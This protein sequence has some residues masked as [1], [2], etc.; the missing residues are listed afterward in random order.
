MIRRAWIVGVSVAA[1]VGC[2]GGGDTGAGG[3]GSGGTASSTGGST[4]SAGGGGSGATGG[5]GGTGGSGGAYTPDALPFEM[6]ASTLADAFAAKDCGP[7]IP[8]PEEDDS[9]TR[10]HLRAAPGTYAAIELATVDGANQQLSVVDPWVINVT[11]VATQEEAEAF[12]CED[13]P[14]PIAGTVTDEVTADDGLGD[15]FTL[16]IRRYD[17]APAT[18]GGEWTVL[19]LQSSVLADTFSNVMICGDGNP[20]R[21]KWQDNV[22]AG[23]AV[24]AMCDYGA[25]LC[26]TWMVHLVE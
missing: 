9:W 3:G 11:H 7:I 24:H 18:L 15:T 19:C 23:S 4:V 25:T 13:G 8:A 6:T 22:A 16:Q 21:D 10:V 26:R 14:A 17:I 1:F 5:G 2:G 20:D 12:D